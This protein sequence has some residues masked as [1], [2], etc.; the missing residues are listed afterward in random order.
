[1]PKSDAAGLYQVPALYEALLGALGEDAAFYLSLA[2]REGGPV[3]DLGCG[4]GRL[5]LALAAAGHSVTGVDASPAML[6]EARAAAELRGLRVDWL[7]ARWEALA[8]APCFALAL[9]P[10]NGLQHL[11]D[12]AGL[13]AVSRAVAAALQPGGHWALDLHVPQ[14]T[15]LSRDPEA[16]LPVTEGPRGPLGERVTA[17]RSA[18]DAAAQVLT[19]SWRVESPAGPRELSLALRQYPVEQLQAF[20]QA[21]AWRVEGLYQS[22]DQR[23]LGPQALRQIWVLQRP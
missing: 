17:E 13:L 22:F 21:Q 6:A 5:S 4:T 11:L 16:W 9:L 18:Y 20:F 10:Y 8:L 1:M 14:P 12:D 19:Q 7:E 15:I 23:P 3:L 2:A